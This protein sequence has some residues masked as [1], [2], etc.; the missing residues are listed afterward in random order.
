MIATQCSCAECNGVKTYRGNATLVAQYD[1]AAL[2]D[3]SLTIWEY[4]RPGAVNVL[5]RWAESMGL[6]VARRIA[7][8]VT[9]YEVQLMPGGHTITVYQSEAE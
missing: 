5:R 7:D 9:V 8:Q 2:G 6:I 1:A 4:R 3:C